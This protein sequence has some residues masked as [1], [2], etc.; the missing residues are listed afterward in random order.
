[1]ISVIIP[2][3]N[4]LKFLPER[5]DSIFNQT[6]QDFEV[7]LLDDC[8]TDGSWEYL[9]SFKNHPKVSYCIRNEVN[10]GSPFAQWKRGIDL[11][12]YDWIWIAESDDFC[13]SSF[14]MKIKFQIKDMNT[15]IYTQS[16][17]VNEENFIK[18][19]YF[20]G[21]FNGI[22]FNDNFECS[23]LNFIES[24]MIFKNYI[25]NASSVVFKKPSTFPNTILTMKTSGDWYFWIYILKSSLKVTFISCP[26]NYYRNHNNSTRSLKSSSDEFLRF[27]EGLICI[28]YGRKL[29]GQKELN[30]FNLKKYKSLVLLLLNTNYKIGKFRLGFFFPEIPWFMYFIYYQLLIRKFFKALK[31]K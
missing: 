11:A 30:F 25:P 9:Q 12:K 3:Y 8:S 2:N 15:L 20:Q 6:F 28:N 29:I 5:L 24:F 16:L 23:G 31:F 26:L 14:L 4:H 21:V 17:I 18:G 22:D 1:M 7:I 13:D 10:S 19:N 27:K